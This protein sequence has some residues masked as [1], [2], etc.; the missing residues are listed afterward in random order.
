MHSH[1]HL[2]A[3]NHQRYRQI[4]TLGRNA[5]AIAHLFLKPTTRFIPSKSFPLLQRHWGIKEWTFLHQPVG[6]GTVNPT[7]RGPMRIFD[8]AVYS[9]G[10]LR[11]RRACRRKTMTQFV[12]R[13]PTAFSAIHGL[14][15]AE[16]VCRSSS[17][18][19]VMDNKEMCHKTL[20]EIAISATSYSL[21]SVVLKRLHSSDATS[22]STSTI[23]PMLLK[24]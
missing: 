19:L 13:G 14:W 5:I 3:R 10:V 20:V 1:N 6:L 22:T 4:K 17:P 11:H 7:Y 24:C 8:L 18:R 21:S 9:H 15:L 16:A 2:T 12:L 23:L